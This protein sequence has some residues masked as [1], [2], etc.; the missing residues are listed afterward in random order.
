[1]GVLDQSALTLGG[2]VRKATD[3]P[4][5][6]PSTASV[7][8]KVASRCNLNCTYCY[9]Y[10]G[11]D[12]AW[13]AQ[14]RVIADETVDN[15]VAFFRRAALEDGLKQLQIIFHGGEPLLA[16]K[17]R[18]HKI[19][20]VLREGFHEVLP[21]SLALQTNATLIDDDWIRVFAAHHIA[22]GVSLDGPPEQNDRRRLTINSRGSYSAAAAG[23]RKLVAARDRGDLSS[24]GLLCVVDGSGDPA[25]LLDH[26]VDDL[27]VLVLDFLLPDLTH[28]DVVV[29]GLIGNYLV[30][31]FERWTERDD[32]RIRIR[33]L[34]SILSLM[35]GGRSKMI[36]FG[37]ETPFAM[38][39][40]TDGAIS[41]D[42]TLRNCG[43]DIMNTGL[44]VGMATFAEFVAS[45]RMSA[46]RRELATLPDG[47]SECVWAKVCR[48]SHLIN[49]F[50][51]VSGF[52][53]PSVLCED[54]QRLYLRIADH[55]VA[56]GHIERLRAALQVDRSY[57]AAEPSPLAQS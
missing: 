10:N 6:W 7:V 9:V 47:C 31:L 18:L 57:E 13:R 48:G 8:F 42:D 1:M 32:P 37:G 43:H 46:V 30:R 35:L 50:S 28:E 22:V 24:V 33:V 2:Q 51:P 21:L 27:G 16:G 20:S 34:S 11:R 54:L 17:E 12:D 44:H 49:R 41:P 38:T 5:E 29:P 36:G 45:P 53:N 39:V 26:F 19:A 55:V 15:T 40:N 3:A 52:N 56:H 14:P 25:I 4:T 23:I